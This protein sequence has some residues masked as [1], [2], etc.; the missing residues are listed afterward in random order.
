MIYINIKNRKFTYFFI[1]IL[2]LY[3]TS[4]ASSQ[5]KEKH[6]LKDCFSIE[7]SLGKDTVLYG[8]TIITQIILKNRTNDTLTIFPNSWCCINHQQET[9]YL[10]QNELYYLNGFE[11]INNPVFNINKKILPKENHLFP[12]PI[13]ITDFFHSGI[14]HIFILL[15][16]N[17]KP[18][19]YVGQIISAPIKL[20]V[21]RRPLYIF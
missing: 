6:R 5:K 13:H 14:N 20:Y 10:K 3:G 8:D 17:E 12:V 15:G 1:L 9:S 16:Y 7:L 11:H 2:L 21:K 18:K 19:E 4:Y